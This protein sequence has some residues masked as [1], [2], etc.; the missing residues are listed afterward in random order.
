[1]FAFFGVLYIIYLIIQGCALFYDNFHSHSSHKNQGSIPI[2]GI[3]W[4]EDSYG[5]DIKSMKNSL[6]HLERE[7]HDDFG[8]WIRSF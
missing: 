4:T 6:E 8:K 2:M 3:D 5:A 7:A 1:M